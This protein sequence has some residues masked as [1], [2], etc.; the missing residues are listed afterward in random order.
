MIRRLERLTYEERLKEAGFFSLEETTLSSIVH[1]GTCMKDSMQD[2]RE[3][4]E[5]VLL[6]VTS[7]RTR[8]NRHKLIYR[9]F[10]IW[11]IFFT[12]RLL[13][14]SVLFSLVGNKNG[15]LSKLKKF[16]HPDRTKRKI[17]SSVFFR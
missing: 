2:S 11:K 17:M 6:V 1:M 3:D 14:C 12:V 8:G 16:P 15:C 13:S 5:G 7:E 10:C 9:K 4:R